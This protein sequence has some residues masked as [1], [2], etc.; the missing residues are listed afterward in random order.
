MQN[1][2]L[3]VVDSDQNQSGNESGYREAAGIGARLMAALLD[4]F[5]VMSVIVGTYLFVLFF[6][7]KVDFQQVQQ[8]EP[9][10]PLY[11]LGTQLGVF[12]SLYLYTAMFNKK[13]GG[14]LGKMMLKIEVIH[15]ESGEYIGWGRTFL[16]D[17]L[18]KWISSIFFIGYI[19]A[20]FT[21]D[22]KAL[23]DI[24]SGTKVVKKD[25]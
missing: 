18:G 9:I 10:N 15:A 25:S 13:F 22:H 8:G 16:R 2:S 14:T 24:I 19:I 6:I 5:L 11:I 21:D 17:F 23:H 1:Q 7:L 3:R 20:F 4:G 12:L